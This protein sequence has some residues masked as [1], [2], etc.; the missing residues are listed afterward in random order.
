MASN[1]NGGTA[2]A[3][4]VVLKFLNDPPEKWHLAPFFLIEQSFEAAF[5]CAAVTTLSR[6]EIGNHLK[7]FEDEL[8]RC[9]AIMS[10]RFRARGTAVVRDSLVELKFRLLTTEF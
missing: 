4:A 7:A 9:L 10:E 6:R 5:P 8:R 2:Q 1:P 3:V